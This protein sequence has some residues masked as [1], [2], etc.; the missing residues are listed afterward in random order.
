ML[1]S[2][3]DTGA[4]QAAGEQAASIAS[5]MAGASRTLPDL[6]QMPVPAAAKNLF[7]SQVTTTKDSV[8]EAIGELNALLQGPERLESAGPGLIRRVNDAPAPDQ[9]LTLPDSIKALSPDGTLTA[10][11][12]GKVRDQLLDAVLKFDQTAGPL[13]REPITPLEP[14]APRQPALPR[15]PPGPTMPPGPI[16][17]RAPSKLDDVLGSLMQELKSMPDGVQQKVGELL[18]RLGALFQQAGAAAQTPPAGESGANAGAQPVG[19]SL[20]EA[21]SRSREVA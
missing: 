21:V 3:I 12:A 4:A 9:K 15:V 18:S 16:L 11:D 7:A 14:I 8:Q 5:S 13:P 17:P 6:R 20:F 19:T 2:R 1:I 10:A